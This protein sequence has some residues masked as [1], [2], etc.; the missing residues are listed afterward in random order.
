MTTALLA[1]CVVV[2]ASL[3]TPGPIAAVTADTDAA[4]PACN[5]QP[6]PN[7]TQLTPQALRQR[8]GIQPLLDAGFDGRGQTGVLLEF[9]QSIDLGT[10]DQWLSCMGVTGP[11]IT[12]KGV[13]GSSI[14]IPPSPCGMPSEPACFNEAQGDVYSMITGAP[15][16][17]RLYVLVS[18]TSELTELPSIL[19][20]LRTGELTD[21]RRPD[22][23]SLSFGTC[24]PDWT[25]RQVADTEAQLRALAEAGTWFFKAAGDAGPSDCSQHPVCDAANAGPAMGYPAASPWVTSVGGTQLLGSTSAH[26]DGQATV[27]NLRDLQPNNPNGCAAG[28]GGLSTFPTPAYQADLP[29]ELLLSSRGLPDISALAGLPGYL[30]LTSGGEWFGNGGTSLASPLYA[31]A[32]A[33]I[34]SKLAAQGLE[35]PRLLNEALYATAADPANYAD[36]FDDVDVGNNRIYP[37]VDCCDAATG[38]DLASGLGE[39]RI[40]VLA[41]VLVQ[42]AQPTQPTTPSTVAPADVVTPTFTG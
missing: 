29:G 36:A 38:Y 34:R 2:T 20:G 31:G 17:D 32:F 11:P 4:L 22:V 42:A 7:P 28:A 39:V 14:P 1:I 13:F 35:P 15:G 9:S 6:L 40:N 10:L 8:Y 41:D 12:Q 5:N 21:G 37:S 25:D 3:A 33:S 19:E 24:Q 18:E 30:N 27:W 26:P 23:V 16:L